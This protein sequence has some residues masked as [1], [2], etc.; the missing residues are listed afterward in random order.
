MLGDKGLSANFRGHPIA[1]VIAVR[2]L[3]K[4]PPHS[5]IQLPPL[6]LIIILTPFCLWFVGPSSV[7]H[8]FLFCFK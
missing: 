8:L 3:L 4:V 1:T 6:L 2:L 5:F 7:F